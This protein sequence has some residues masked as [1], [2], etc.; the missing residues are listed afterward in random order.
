MYTKLNEQNTAGKMKIF[1]SQSPTMM[2]QN[3]G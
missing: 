3:E 2:P 1:L